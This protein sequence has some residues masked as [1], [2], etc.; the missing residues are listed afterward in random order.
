[1][2]NLDIYSLIV[3]YQLSDKKLFLNRFDW[4]SIKGFRSMFGFASVILPIL[5][6]AS[7]HIILVRDRSSKRKF[8]GQVIHQLYH[9]YQEYRFGYFK[10]MLY[11]FMFHKFMENQAIKAQQKAIE[12]Y[13]KE[14][15]N[16][17]SDSGFQG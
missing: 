6:I 10:F 15:E 3:R 11:Y 17:N 9:A 8:F 7:E 1:M 14:I 5:S 12:W 2:K 13:Q 4:R 16:D